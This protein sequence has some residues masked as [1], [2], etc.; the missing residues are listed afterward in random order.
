MKSQKQCDRMKQVCVD[1][2]LNYWNESYAFELLDKEEI[3]G[4][5][6]DC[7]L[8]FII[9]GGNKPYKIKVTEKQFMKLLKE[10]KHGN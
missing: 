10:Y 2:G 5:S 1:N 8:F 3:F 9:C 7:N 4:Y 6:T